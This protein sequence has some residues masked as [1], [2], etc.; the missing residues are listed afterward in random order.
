M[1]V[2]AVLVARWEAAYR[3]YADLTRTAGREPAEPASSEALASVSWEVAAAWRDIATS[4]PL[5]WWALAALRAAAEAFE[6]QARRW[7]TG[8]SPS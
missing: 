5:P 4:S 3:Q 1:T 2:P 6:R 7:H 8:N